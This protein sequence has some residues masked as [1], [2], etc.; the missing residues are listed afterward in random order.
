MFFQTLIF[1]QSAPSY[2]HRRPRRRLHRLRRRLGR[3]QRHRTRWRKRGPELGNNP[4][5]TTKWRPTHPVAH[6]IT[7]RRSLKPNGLCE[8][9]ST[10]SAKQQCYNLLSHAMAGYCMRPMSLARVGIALLATA[11]NLTPSRR[12]RAPT[13]YRAA[14][15]SHLRAWLGI[16]ALAW[17]ALTLPGVAV[18]LSPQACPE[19]TCPAQRISCRS[20][21]VVPGTQRALRR[22]RRWAQ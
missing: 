11:Q 10:A 17:A 4:F 2:H 12:F 15:W 7:S 13:S 22:G 8:V 5:C 19:W 20:T 3:S 21:G 1:S 14:I 18:V 9:L 6:P 16:R